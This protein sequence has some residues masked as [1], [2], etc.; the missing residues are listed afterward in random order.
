[1]LE[2]MWR[3]MKPHTLLVGLQIGT[4]TMEDSV[5]VPQKTKN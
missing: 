5:E 2:R 3:K 4:A 1:M